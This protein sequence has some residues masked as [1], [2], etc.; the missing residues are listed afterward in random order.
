MRIYAA[1]IFFQLFALATFAQSKKVLL[2]NG[3]TLTPAGRTV[4]LGD[5][6]LNIAISGDG[7]YFAVTNN[8]VGT[9]SIQLIN[10]KTYKVLCTCVIDK[11]WLGLKF[12]GNSKYLYASGGNDN[13]IL[14]YALMHD[15]LKLA[16]G[17]QKNN[18]YL[19]MK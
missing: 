4:A 16:D 8:G 13:R 3:W 7:K 6:P 12:S 2:P 19:T 15:T 9:Q 5:L 14:K 18:Q 1:I 17:S 10:A 11:S